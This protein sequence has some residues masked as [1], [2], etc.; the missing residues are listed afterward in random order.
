MANKKETG[1]NLERI[2]D[3]A[4]SV[5]N[6]GSGKSRVYYLSEVGYDTAYFNE[7]AYNNLLTF[8]SR[9][10]DVTGVLVD[11]AIT[12]LDRPEYLNDALT[13]WN[14]SES[15]CTAAE[16]EVKNRDQ[17]MAMMRVQ[18]GIVEDRL[19]EL[20][21]KVPDS[22]KV[23]LSLHSDDLQY[24]A[25]AMLNEMLIRKQHELQEGIEQL[26]TKKNELKSKRKEFEK[27]Y[28]RLSSQ[29]S[30]GSDAASVKKKIDT[31]TTK[32]DGIEEKLSEMYAE[33]KVYREK[34]VRPKH[35]FVTQEF[36][37]M[38]NSAY[39]AM[40]ARVGVELVMEE[41]RIDFN[42]MV[43]DYSHSR[44][45]TWNVQ[46]SRD[47]ELVRGLHGKLER[48]KGVDIVLESGHHGIGYKQL[49]KVKDTPEETNFANQ[50][51]YDPKTGSNHVTIVLG[52]PFEDQERI[53]EFVKGRRFVRLSGG[54][55]M[56]TRK[57]AATDRY[58]ND[59]VSGL[60][61]LTKDENGII[62]TEWV[63]YRNFLD[64]SALKPVESPSI[65]AASSDEHI[66]SP[67]SN[68]I[69]RLGW[70]ELYK[71]LLKNPATYRGKEA[72]ARGYINA[73]DI[74]EANS[75]KW[76]HRYHHK[77]GADEVLSENLKL[78]AGFEP[79]SI[80][81]IVALAMKMTNDST[82][83]SFESMAVVMDHVADY[84]DNFV[85]G[86]IASSS[87]KWVVA[88]VTGNHADAVLRDLGIRETDFLKQRLKGR[89]VSVSEVGKPGYISQNK[90]D[91]ARVML[92]GYS[93]ARILQIPDY[94][95]DV[96][97]KPLFGP[98]NLVVQHDPKGEGL[99]GAIGAG[100][101]SGADLTLA[102]H[103][104]DNRMRL[105]RTAENAFGVAYKLG[106]LQGVSPTEKYYAYSV[107]R[108]Q[109]AHCIVMPMP[110]D[111]T[112]KA[113][114]ASYLSGLG[115][116]HIRDSV[117]YVSKDRKKG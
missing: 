84:L 111:F 69:A 86:T 54:K 116:K 35:Q 75:R 110:G 5:G 37:D 55:P 73:G 114:P 77:R 91:D 98:I 4:L 47:R 49:Q 21:K 19:K 27:E 59:S 42:G 32:V 39:K 88:A 101:N 108:T 83:G 93:L 65:I 40:C 81:D 10:R 44:H 46:K 18:M 33:Q 43:I 34:K 48:L 103:T 24:T 61:I 38:I 87:L 22:A 90:G 26:K 16:K 78:L 30:A 45:K 57:I 102:G 66:D 99:D 51:T 63:Q 14:R 67:E 106:T 115:R 70:V 58:S 52:L 50:S 79:K 82:G 31:T 107:P 36:L 112:E 72:F 117:Q 68:T 28:S 3:S 97:G 7:K 60:T 76:D 94:G 53:G 23:V 89:G 96:D 85:S 95:L 6:A 113:I 13:Y 25:S 15:E 71:N 109:S 105:Y 1:K 8:M 12:R 92:G 2:V 64:A 56:S 80:D 29:P 104:H 100:K 41:S 20:K 62:G 17:Y 9:D 74:A 11:G